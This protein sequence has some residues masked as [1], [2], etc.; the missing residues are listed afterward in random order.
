MT[1]EESPTEKI[2]SWYF[3]IDD[4]GDVTMNTSYDE[5]AFLVWKGREFEYS[6]TLGLVK[7][8]DL[9]GNELVGE[10]PAEITSLVGLLGLDL[11]TNNLTGSIPLKIGQLRAINF[12]DLSING[13]S[14]K[15]PTSFS[16]LSHLGVL[17]LSYNNLSA[18]L[19][20]ELP[21]DPKLNGDSEEQHEDEFISAGIYIGVGTGFV[22]G[23]WGSFLEHNLDIFVIKP[24]GNTDDLIKLKEQLLPILS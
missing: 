15:I 24:C 21:H 20:D 6:S 2:K 11:S 12:L 23:F 14:G 17:N 8:I 5:S 10:I 19:G 7:T 9:S 16:Q 1:E 18:C 3:Q 13:L 22:F 4:E